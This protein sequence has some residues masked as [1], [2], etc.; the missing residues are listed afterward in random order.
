MLF[1]SFTHSQSEEDKQLQDDL[2]MMVE[3]L[4]VSTRFIALIYLFFTTTPVC[5]CLKALKYKKSP[6]IFL[7]NGRRR[8]QP[9]T[10]QH[11]RSC[12]DKYVPQP[13]PWPQ[14]PSPSNSCAHTMASSKRSMRA[15]LLERT[16]LGFTVPPTNSK[17]QGIFFIYTFFFSYEKCVYFPKTQREAQ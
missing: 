15:W 4:S 13:P 6:H 8:T 10:V 12:A 1:S 2:E 3:R 9:C 14:Y 17:I 5:L 16:R 11:W 7:I